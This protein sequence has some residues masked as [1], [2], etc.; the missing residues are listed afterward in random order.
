MTTTTEDPERLRDRRTQ[1]WRGAFP[2]LLGALRPRQWPKNLL[3]AAAPA[4]AG[5]L[6]EAQA[7]A[8]C[9]SVFVLFCVAAGGTYL[10]NDVRDIERDRAHPRKRHRPIASG[11]VPVPVAVTVGS[12][13]VVAAPAA[14]LLLGDPLLTGILTGYVVLTLAYTHRLKDIAVL[15]LV[16][17]ASCHVLRAAAG[18]VAAGVPLSSW[19]VAVVSLAALLVVTGKREVE[20][21]AL[22]D[23]P[24]PGPVRA[25]LNVYTP[26]CLARTRTAVSA[27]MILTYVLWAFEQG[28]GNAFHAAS[29]LPFTMFVLRYNLL[30]DRGTGE[31]PEEIALRDRPLQLA[32]AS[33][34]TL[35]CLG[36][37]L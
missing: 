15:D 35:V 11:R 29:T 5:T 2:A 22:A 32:G 1:R 18:G 30:V 3:V 21:R 20:L 13:L 12:L 17:V 26:A 4:A 7:A 19:F 28:G 23:R 36:I 24:T 37:H 31:E 14:S 25:V 33:L 34:L 27:A 6:T 8:A 9:A 10:L 16:A